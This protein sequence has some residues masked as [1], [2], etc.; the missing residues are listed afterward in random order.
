MRE[1]VCERGEIQSDR[2]ARSVINTT[3]SKCKGKE[4]EDKRR[5]R[6]E[7]SS[8][9]SSIR[10]VSA[11]EVICAS[12]CE[13][14]QLWSVGTANLAIGLPASPAVSSLAWPGLSANYR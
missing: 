11:E 6:A 9:Q 14:V 13:K 8:A 12:K 4:K 7:I 5:Q 10:A 2:M 3:T 1:K